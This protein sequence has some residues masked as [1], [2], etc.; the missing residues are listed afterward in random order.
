M[1]CNNNNI[2][3][4]FYLL[5]LHSTVLKQVKVVVKAGHG[6]CLKAFRLYVSAFYTSHL[7]DGHSSVT[8]R[9]FVFQDIYVQARFRLRYAVLLCA[10][11][12]GSTLQCCG[13]LCYGGL[14]VQ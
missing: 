14:P 7:G 5:L 10:V 11:A 6:G 8:K 1:K 9:A 4:V 13:F 2:N 12:F 3:G